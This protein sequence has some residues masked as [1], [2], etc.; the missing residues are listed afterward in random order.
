MIAQQK[1]YHQTGEGSRAIRFAT[2][3]KHQGGGQQETGGPEEHP[4]VLRLYSHP[5]TQHLIL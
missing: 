3:N 2:E 1:E 5:R 4:E